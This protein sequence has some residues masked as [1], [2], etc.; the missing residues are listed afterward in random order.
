[1][2]KSPKFDQT[3]DSWNN[4][5]SLGTHSAISKCEADSSINSL[6]FLTIMACPGT[7]YHLVKLKNSCVSISTRSLEIIMCSPQLE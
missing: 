4:M 5:P 3:N 6:Y 7:H 2:P 1:M